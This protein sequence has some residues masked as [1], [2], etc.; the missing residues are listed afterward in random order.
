MGARYFGASVLRAEDASLLTGH[1]AYVDDITRPGMLHAA[2]VRAEHAHALIRGIGTGAAEKLAGVACV[3]TND[4]L[5][6]D[7]R[8]RRMAQPYPAPMLKQGIC[9]HVLAAGEVNHVGQTVAMVVA[10][11]R[12]VAEDAAALVEVDYEPLDAVV[13]CRKAYGQGAPLVHQGA[14]D[15]LAATLRASFGAIDQAFA[16]AAHVV[17]T[18]DHHHRGGCHAMETRGAIGEDD[19]A[20]GEATLWSSTQCPYLVRRLVAR[21]LDIPESSLRVIAPDVGGGFGPKAG[22]YPEEVMVVVAARMLGLPVKWIEDRREHFTATQ[23]QR[24]QFWELEAAVAAD[25]RVLGVRGTVIHDN[26]A[27]VPYGLLLPFTTLGPLPGP[28]AIANL[29]VTLEAVFTNTTPNSPVRGAGR[30]NAAYAMERVMA[31]VARELKLDPADVRRRNFVPRDAFPYATGARNRAGLPVKYDSGDYHGCLEKAVALAG[32]ESFPQRQAEARKEGRFLGIGISACVEDTGIG[33]YEGATVRV[34][35]SGKVMV[36]TG[37]AGQGQGHKTVLK[38]IVA[39]ALGVAFEDVRV[40]AGDTGR[41][42]QGVGAIG[43]RTAVTV[44]SSAHQAASEVAATALS[45]AA[46]ILELPQSDLEL[47]GGAVRGS[48]DHNVFI[49]LGDLAQR[50]APMAGGTVPKG[51]NASLEATAYAT[52]DGQPYANGT[53][54]AEVEVDIGTGEV[55]VLRY[56]VAHDCGNMINPLIVDGQITGGVI[57]GI[58]NALYEEMVYDPSGQPLTT[59][60]GEYLL[61]LASEMPRVDI[62]HQETPSP[63]NPL[64]IKGAGEGGTIPATAA[65]VA[66]IE[67]ALKDYGVVIDRYP[68]TPERLCGLI[69]AGMAEAA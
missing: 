7:L 46:E 62:V 34:D 54:I 58:G 20:R 61:P 12:H 23:T 15:N 4:T 21:H 41:F 30:P 50:L 24:D 37:A 32:Y 25:G 40:E 11:S 6:A 22:V 16:E 56:S 42:A 44:G 53:N 29:D 2:F 52:A 1:G 68:V 8:D 48:G 31:A 9:A 3:L 28:Y 63:T 36:L 67:N 59:N 66:A 19:P 13:D 18:S 49:T 35:A 45:L 51:F 47:A 57:H 5:P 39:D 17:R 69:D 33:P 55:R 64:G 38:Q 10:T 27:F 43:S 14:P 60:Y 65:V 26:G